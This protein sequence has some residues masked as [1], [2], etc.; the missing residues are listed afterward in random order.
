[1][2][3]TYSNSQKAPYFLLKANLF[4]KPFII[5]KT[6][7]NNIIESATIKVL[8]FYKNSGS[9]RLKS[10]YLSSGFSFSISEIIDED[11][12]PIRKA[13]KWLANPPVIP[14]FAWPSLAKAIQVNPSG[15]ALP[16]D[17]NTLPKYGTGIAL[18][19]PKPLK[20]LTNKSEQ[21]LFH[22]KAQNTEIIQ[23][24]IKYFGGVQSFFGLININKSY[25]NI[26]TGISTKLAP[27]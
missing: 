12:N 21:I 19:N 20:I 18:I 16:I 24:R 22:S 13:N 3:D 15:K 11:P 25:N 6:W 5:A 8:F 26:K 2:F 17:K 9:V 1:M 10:I 7:L 4:I 14:I 23:T 27:L